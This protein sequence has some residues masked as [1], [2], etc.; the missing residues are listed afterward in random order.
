ME[1]N[2]LA[3]DG[4]LKFSALLYLTDALVKQEYE[5]CA[6]LIAVAKQLGAEQSEINDVLALHIRGDKPARPNGAKQTANR[7]Q[8]L[9]EE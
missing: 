3:Q 6:E 4:V 2:V 9:K 1:S 7:L 8:V 5:S